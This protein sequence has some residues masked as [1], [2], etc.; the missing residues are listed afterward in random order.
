MH[1]R[2]RGSV[3]QPARKA[4]CEAVHQEW[5]F[6][7]EAASLSPRA[8]RRVRCTLSRPAPRTRAEPTPLRAGERQCSEVPRASD[9]KGE[10]RLL[11]PL[12]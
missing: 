1:L 7:G 10:R 3:L 6:G 8:W 9:K 5:G 4:G 2:S 11:P 12:T